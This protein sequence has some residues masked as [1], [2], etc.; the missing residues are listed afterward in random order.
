MEEKINLYKF[1]NKKL[2]SLDCWLQY[3]AEQEDYIEDTSTEE[4]KEIYD[5]HQNSIGE[6][7]KILETLDK[8]LKLYN[9]LYL[10]KSVTDEKSE[11]Y[12]FGKLSEIESIINNIKIYD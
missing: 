10:S 4:G 11:N 7:R 8:D 5:S 1:N 3:Q 2:E 6:L 9:D 12:Y